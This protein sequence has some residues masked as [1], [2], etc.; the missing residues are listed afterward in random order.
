MMIQ[1]NSI[2]FLFI[3]VSSQ[4]PNVQ[5]QKQHDIQ[6][7]INKGR[8]TGH[9]WNKLQMHK[10]FRVSVPAALTNAKSVPWY[11]VQI[12]KRDIT[13]KSLHVPSCENYSSQCS[14]WLTPL[15]DLHA[16][17]RCSFHLTYRLVY[18]CNNNLIYIPNFLLYASM[19]QPDSAVWQP[20][21][22]MTA[23]LYRDP[24]CWENFWH[25]LSVTWSISP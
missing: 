18:T 11:D 6:T 9:K 21:T 4:Q 15:Y 22:A 1:F 13:D 14:V 8:Q 19:D 7:K 3:N 16:T 5:L 10:K 23:R 25:I 24:S 12:L 2:H 17:Q 20:G